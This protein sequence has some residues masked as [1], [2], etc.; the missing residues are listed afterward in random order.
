MISTANLIALDKGGAKFRPIAI[1]VDMRRLITKDLMP[2]SIA[3]AKAHLV[4]LQVDC[5]AKSGLDVIVY[6]TR[7]AFVKLGS[8]RRLSASPSTRLTP[9]SRHSEPRCCLRPSFMRRI[10]SGSPTPFTQRV[11]HNSASKTDVC[12][13]RRE[14]S[15]AIRQAPS[16]SLPH[17]RSRIPSDRPTHQ[18]GARPLLTPWV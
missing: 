9:L 11:N 5:G 13:V 6:N 3:E 14:S 1:G 8:N 17:V 10:S 15:R 12:A 2:A 16:C 7:D 4:P 18:N